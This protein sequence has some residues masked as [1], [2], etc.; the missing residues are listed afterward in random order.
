M[1][2]FFP[3]LGGLGMHGLDIHHSV[4]LYQHPLTLSLY[5]LWSQ[6]VARGAPREVFWQC[7]RPALLIDQLL[8]NPSPEIP[9][10][11]SP[12]PA[13]ASSSKWARGRGASRAVGKKNG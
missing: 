12:E 13:A 1:L 4:F 5:R 9:V 3:G 7:S 8:C 10:H 6:V 11:I 2:L